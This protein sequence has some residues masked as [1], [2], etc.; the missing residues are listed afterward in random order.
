[1]S[2]IFHPDDI[3]PE[4]VADFL[5][6]L[7]DELEEIESD[8]L[9]LEKQPGDKEAIHS[10]FRAVHSI[11]G[12]AKMCFFDPISEFVHDIEEALSEVRSGRL[13]FTAL[14]GEAVLLSLDQLK[15][16]S[17]Q[18]ERDGQ[19][20]LSQ[21]NQIRPLFK[22]IRD[23]QPMEAEEYAAKVIQLIG[24]GA[25]SV[26]PLKTRDRGGE[27][28]SN[29]GHIESDAAN[30]AIDAET[31]A[32]FEEL[33]AVIDAKCTFWEKRTSQQSQIALGINK[34]LPNSVDVTQLKAAVMLHDIGMVF[35]PEGLINKTQKF[36]ALEAKQL[37]QHVRWSYEWLRR[38]PHWDEA[39][40]MVLQHH[41]R[42]DGNGYPN[43]LKA[44]QIHDGAQIIAIVD[45]FYSITNERSDRTYKKSLMRAI[46]EIN[47]YKGIQFNDHIVDAFNELIRLIYT[48]KSE[49]TN[50]R[51]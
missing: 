7:K 16:K 4:M 40:T 31:Y 49:K 51:G 13:N 33:A 20:D 6:G 2:D 47:S 19:M 5:D 11:K 39:A 9:V 26:I 41:E 43:Q 17:E 8:L 24:G 30:K 34:F 25:A 14:I 32:Y 44:D 48:R 46:T 50:G 28:S 38:I 42:P 21:F 22:K 35:L 37:K 23:A 15:I 36:N 18:L 1:M 45:T 10:L 3:D 12:N 27:V 29:V